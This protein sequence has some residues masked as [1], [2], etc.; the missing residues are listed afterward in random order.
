MDINS[1]IK[2][3]S[4][5]AITASRFE[6]IEDKL[7][8]DGKPAVYSYVKIKPGIC[9]IVRTDNGFAVLK[10]YRYPIKQ[11][12]YEFCA[13]IIDADEA[14]DAAAM[15]EVREETG[16]IADTVTPLGEFYPSFGATDEVIHL[17]YAECTDKTETDREFTEFIEYEFMSEAEID[18]LI[19]S[20]EFRH[21]AGIAAWLKYKL[22]IGS[23]EEN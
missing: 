8:V 19:R 10:E 2:V 13:G 17:F 4:G 15:R 14:P 3:I 5:R 20:G 6:I 9:V 23:K 1:K 16:C 21:G 18:S 12:S 22:L 11:F 7:E